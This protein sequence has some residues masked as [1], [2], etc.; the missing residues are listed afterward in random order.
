MDRR[1]E[2]V[3]TP[4]VVNCRHCLHHQALYAE[5]MELGRR[6]AWYRCRSCENWFAVRWDDAVA[7]RQAPADALAG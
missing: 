4:I 2:E 6:R 1:Q 3:T 7:L 5:R